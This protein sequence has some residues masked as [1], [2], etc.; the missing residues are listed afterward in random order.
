MIQELQQKITP[1]ERNQLKNWEKQITNDEI[2]ESDLAYF[3]GVDPSKLNEIQMKV[4]SCVIDHARQNEKYRRKNPLRVVIQG[5]PGTGKS[6]MIKCLQKE[7][8]DMTVTGA[9]TAQA[10]A[11][12]RGI[13]LHK[14]FSLRVGHKNHGKLKS[15]AL[16]R[17][18]MQLEGIEYYVL[19]EYSM[20]GAGTLKGISDRLQ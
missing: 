19:D 12:I 11:S 6:Y 18:V 16:G 8:K 5:E 1:E 14:L 17:L 7:L 9:Y 20:I 15:Q 3:D 2:I 10:A 4:Y 13:T